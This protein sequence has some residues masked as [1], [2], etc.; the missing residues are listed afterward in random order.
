MKLRRDI[1]EFNNNFYDQRVP[2]RYSYVVYVS[3]I[4]KL[5]R[6]NYFLEFTE[7]AP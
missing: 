1:K 6:I 5:M 2:N 3:V 4:K 7:F